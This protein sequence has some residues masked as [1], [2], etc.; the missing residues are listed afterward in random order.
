MNKKQ[1]SFKSFSFEPVYDN[2]SLQNSLNTEMNLLAELDKIIKTME[3]IKEICDISIVVDEDETYMI[4]EL[5]LPIYHYLCAEIE[6]NF[7]GK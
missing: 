1:F 7:F 2:A 4:Q 6:A 3:T 5:H